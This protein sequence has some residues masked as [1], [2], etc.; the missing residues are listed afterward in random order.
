MNGRYKGGAEGEIVPLP[1]SSVQDLTMG[2]VR[3]L[4]LSCTVSRLKD[5]IAQRPCTKVSL[6]TEGFMLSVKQPKTAVNQP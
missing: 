5:L 6:E 2:C 1:S 4:L 3:T